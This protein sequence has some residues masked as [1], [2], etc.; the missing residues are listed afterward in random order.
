MAGLQYCPKTICSPSLVELKVEVCASK[1][2][3][4]AAFENYMKTD[5][6]VSYGKKKL[7]YS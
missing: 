1:L 2:L 4:A 5:T 3:S 7:I 6:Q